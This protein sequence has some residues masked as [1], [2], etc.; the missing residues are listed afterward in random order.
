M[1]PP[2]LRSPLRRWPQ[3][4]V[5]WLLLVALPVLGTASALLSMLGPQHHASAAIVDGIGADITGDFA[6]DGPAGGTLLPTGPPASL[7]RL[8]PVVRRSRHRMPPSARWRNCSR[9][10]MERPPRAC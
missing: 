6:G 10:R 2:T 3:R 5:L 4:V 8:Q 9:R 1:P 7:H